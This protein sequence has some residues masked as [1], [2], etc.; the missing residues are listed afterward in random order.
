MI[1]KVDER[2]AEGKIKKDKQR[3]DCL[4]HRPFKEHGRRFVSSPGTRSSPHP[5]PYQA[6]HFISTR[7]PV[8]PAALF[9]MHANAGSLSLHIRAT[10]TSSTLSL[11]LHIRL[12]PSPPPGPST[13]GWALGLP[14]PGLSFLRAAY[15]LGLLACIRLR[16]FVL[17]GGL[18][19]RPNETQG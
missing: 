11:S 4:T 7:N 19:L 16:P 1:R 5:Y 15:P 14:E 13:S 9:H 12:T 2:E 17:R 18:S 8:L 3:G 10:S 6:I